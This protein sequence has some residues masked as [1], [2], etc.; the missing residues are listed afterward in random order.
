MWINVCTN[1]LCFCSFAISVD[2]CVLRICVSVISVGPAVEICYYRLDTLRIV[3][4]SLESAAKSVFIYIAS[5][6]R[7]VR[8]VTL[9]VMLGV[10]SVET[11]S[12]SPI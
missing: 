1:R 6:V 5:Q 12:S 11:S 2:L 10:C 9:P 7:L 8:S 3:V 4:L